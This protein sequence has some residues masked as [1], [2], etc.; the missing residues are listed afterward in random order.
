MTNLETKY[1]QALAR[2]QSL[3][4]DFERQRGETL[5]QNEAAINYRIMEQEIAT[6]KTLLDG[7]LQRNKENE[8]ILAQL[9]RNGRI[10]N[11]DL[12][13]AVGLSRAR[14]EGLADVLPGVR[15]AVEAYVN[16]ARQAPWQEAVCS[17]LN[18]VVSRIPSPEATIVPAAA[19]SQGVEAY[20]LRLPAGTTSVRQ[21]KAEPL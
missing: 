3:R 1:R 12:A 10:T 18:T 8:A 16:F 20:S 7:M 4:L 14:V 11:V 5:T 19:S 17:S 9:Q 21:V 13:D 15:F 2:E 6:N